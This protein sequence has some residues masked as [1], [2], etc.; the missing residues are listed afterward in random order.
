MSKSIAVALTLVLGIFLNQCVV[1]GKR[2]TRCGLTNLLNDLGFERSYIG[3]WVCLIESESG[4]NTS[5]VSTRANNRLGLGLF[6]ILSRDWCT[7]RKRGGMCNVHCE[8]M[9]DEYLI[10]DANC[11]KKIMQELGFKAWNG[12]KRGCKN[13]NLPM[14]L[15]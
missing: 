9:L 13:R 4:K 12:W 8:D 3:H 5:K 1:T 15:C 11:A 10:D 14:P 7:F 6:Q 2:Y